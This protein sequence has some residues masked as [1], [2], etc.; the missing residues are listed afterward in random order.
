[1]YSRMCVP[2]APQMAIVG[3]DTPSIFTGWMG[4]VGISQESLETL[5]ARPDFTVNQVWEG[6]LTWQPDTESYVVDNPDRLRGGVEQR[7]IDKFLEIVPW[8]PDWSAPMETEGIADGRTL[9]TLFIITKIGSYCLTASSR[10]IGDTAPDL[11]CYVRCR[12]SFNKNLNSGK[13]LEY[14]VLPLPTRTIEMDWIGY[15]IKFH[16]LFQVV[17]HGPHGL[18]LR[19]P[20]LGMY[21]DEKQRLGDP[22]IGSLVELA[23]MHHKD[24]ET[25]KTAWRVP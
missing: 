13:V 6:W 25:G 5:W 7:R 21:V 4:R 18:E 14:E 10:R 24:K 17:R 23:I 19:N 11:G 12:V 3:W 8:M 20:I 1:V 16:A 9:S 15:L 2:T 22:D